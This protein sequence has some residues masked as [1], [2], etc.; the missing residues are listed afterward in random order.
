[1]FNNPMSWL[2]LKLHFIT[3]SLGFRFNATTI[4]FK[5]L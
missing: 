2:K 1:M 5:R 3:M 4:N